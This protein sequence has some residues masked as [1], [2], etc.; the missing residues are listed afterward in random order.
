M[1]K[2]IKRILVGL[3]A[4]ILIAAIAE[5]W[6]ST[7]Q[8]KAQTGA[9]TEI[10]NPNRF[11]NSYEIIGIKNVKVLNAD[12]VYFTVRNVVLKNGLI[13][14]IDDPTAENTEVEYI[15]GTGK[16]LIP[17][18][19]DTHVH[20]AESK[21]DLYLYLANGVTSVCEMFGTEQHLTWKQ[22]KRQGAI[23]PHLYVSSPKVGSLSGF[24]ANM[25]KYYGGATHFNTE[26]AAA[27]GV[28][29]FK[30]QGYDAIKLSSFLRLDIYNAII[31][32]A[33]KLGIPVIGHL[34]E[35]IGLENLYGSGQS[36]LAHVEEITKNTMSAFGGLEYDNTEEYLQYLKSKAD[37]IAINLAEND[38]S[39][40]TTIWLME[41]L[42]KQKFDLDNFIKTIELEYANLG[43]VEGSE[44]NK[45]WLPGN[46]QYE[47]LEIKNDPER[48]PNSERFWKTYVEAIRIMTRALAKNGVTIL[49]GTDANVACTVPGFSLHDELESL[50]KVGLLNEEVLYAATAAA[51]DFMNENTGRIQ[52]GKEAD[53]ILLSANPLENIK[54]TRDIER[55]FFD[56]FTINKDKIEEMLEAVAESN[57]RNRD[58]DI[59][60][61]L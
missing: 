49:A 58:V 33:N 47:N 11:V 26:E 6:W 54:N 19:I 43:I 12:S 21:N 50:V 8:I 4:L 10:I 20:L 53:L 52:V 28:K 1:K 24:N 59:S 16:Y 37:S 56:R 40:S 9:Y 31:D 23:S 15:D 25:T 61:H 41:S 13:H 60:R 34:A 29:I 3:V 42:P 51:A 38:I 14:S 2:Q 45:G 35:E 57:N 17:G 46:N 5:Y 36:E 27:I 39:V 55:V 18:L 22:E 30:D 48:R 32:E 7:N 44:F